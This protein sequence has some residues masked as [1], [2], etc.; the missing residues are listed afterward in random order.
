MLTITPTDYKDL[1]EV[2]EAMLANHIDEDTNLP[3]NDATVWH[4]TIMLIGSQDASWKDAT[5]ALAIISHT[6]DNFKALA[7]LYEPFKHHINELLYQKTDVGVG[8]VGDTRV[9]LIGNPIADQHRGI[10]FDTRD[11]LFLEENNQALAVRAGLIE[12]FKEM[13]TE[14]ATNNYVIPYGDNNVPSSRGRFFK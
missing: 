5:E 2:A 11:F 6:E 8:D 1:R 14:V 13:F 7:P 12:V 10:E 3:V 9:V 4:G